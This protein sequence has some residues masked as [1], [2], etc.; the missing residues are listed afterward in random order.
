MTATPDAIPDAPETAPAAAQAPPE[1]PPPA[2]PK[3]ETIEIYGQKIPTADVA[4]YFDPSCDLRCDDGAL[5]RGVPAPK[6]FK[7]LRGKIFQ[8]TGLCPCAVRGY[9]RVF[10]APVSPIA[11]P[12][13]VAAAEEAVEPA[14]GPTTSPRADQVRRKR[15]RQDE[16]VAQLADL[17]ARA[18]ARTTALRDE[19]AAMQTGARAAEE[20]GAAARV[21]V[22]RLEQVLADLRTKSE[23]AESTAAE[24]NKRAA[25]LNVEIAAAMSDIDA[26]GAQRL[27]REIE[28]LG[29]QI[30]TIIAYHPEASDGR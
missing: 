14:P 3:I 10:P 17:R 2:E 21:E 7:E 23:A 16:L 22:A 19:L 30:G 6:E 5:T 25:S 4:E 24:A 27:E 28:K 15:A 29:R 9:K 26:K 12:R 18:D 11:G 1:S 8:V 13:A 20:I